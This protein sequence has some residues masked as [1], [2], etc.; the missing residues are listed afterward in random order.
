[1]PHLFVNRPRLYDLT[2]D[3]EDLKAQYRWEVLNANLYNIGGLVFIVGS[4]L[5]F[6]ALAD[7]ADIG[8]WT[9]FAGSILYLIV[10]GHDMAEAIRHSRERDRAALSTRFELV[11][12]AAYLV[13]T[14][15]FTAGSIFFLSRVGW[16]TLGAWCFVIGS[17]LFVLGACI[18]VLQIVRAS[19]LATLQ[20]MNLTAVSFVVGSVLFT[21][22]SVPYL[23]DVAP[24]DEQVLY[25]FLALQYLIG[26]VL[27]LL[28]GLFNYRRAYLVISREIGTPAGGSGA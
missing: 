27:F 6:P 24:E 17:L 23:W 13:G 25:R 20:L 10:T 28:G 16:E 4:I 7:Y 3:S 18:N 21:V 2:R 22:A 1:M 14:S 15:L 12:G 9:F 26:S 11:A 5:F 19:T 8:A